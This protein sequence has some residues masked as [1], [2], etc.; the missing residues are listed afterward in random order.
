MGRERRV[1]E[2][3][4]ER[5]KVSRNIMERKRKIREREKRGLKRKIGRERERDE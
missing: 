4:Q 3:D 5:G 1:K 2:K